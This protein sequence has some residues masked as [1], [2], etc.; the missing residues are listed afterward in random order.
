MAELA[1]APDLGSGAARRVGSTPSTRTNSS[2]YRQNKEID[3]QVKELKKDGLKH[4]IEVTLSANDIDKR[5]DSKLQ[6]V[7]K[8]IRM[9]GFRAGKVPLKMLKQKYGKVI[10]GEVL[11]LA[12]NETSTK[13]LNDKNLKPA[14]QPKIEVRSF[15]EGKDLVFSMAV[16][17]LPEFKVKDFKGL[18]LQR[19]ISKPDDKAVNEALEKI[20]ANNKGS[21]AVDRKAKK[22]DT[23]VIDFHG[24][25]A[26]DNKAHEGMHMHG[27]RLELGSGAFI[28]GFEDQLIGA[29]AGE[30]VEVKVSFP[31]EY[32]AAELAGRDAIFDVDVTEVREPAEAKIDEDF[33]KSLGLDDVAALKNAVR[34]QLQKE[35]DHH[36]RLYLK[37]ALM[38]K[39]DE[40]H[41][42]AVPEGMATMEYENIIQQVERDPS[43][44]KDQ[45]LTQEEKDEFREI[46]ER[47]VRLG[48]L[49][50][51]IGND[52]KI[53]VSDPEL[54]RA[55][56]QQAQQFRGQERQVFEYYSKNRNALESLRAP[57][58]EEK[59]VDFIIALSD[60]TD[61]EVSGDELLNAIENEEQELQAK[62]KGGKKAAKSEDKA[63]KE[64][65]PKVSKKKK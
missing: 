56:I 47:R 31:K 65:K 39:L 50:S 17:V 64:E 35:F 63:D 30:K 62:K 5:V 20:A 32:Q 18:K 27:H 11:E 54:Q 48:L 1:D 19:L 33:A 57:L 4:E 25:T 16:E 42:F 23:V 15:D 28:P 51:Q 44:P 46:A 43:R 12:V 37:K 52:N 40:T 8:T 26:D 45:K 38:D 49:L 6:E 59:V 61:K 34:E 58:F 14:L 24:R 60:V 10:M 22:G 21:K 36:S 7:G 3:M 41:D 29:K 55:V 13:I 53:T 9:P 2:K